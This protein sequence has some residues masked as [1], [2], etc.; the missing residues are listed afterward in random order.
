MTERQPEPVESSRFFEHGFVEIEGTD[1][2]TRQAALAVQMP[3]CLFQAIVP[4][5]LGAGFIDNFRISEPLCIWIP[6]VSKERLSLTGA[7]VDN[8]VARI[9][10]TVEHQMAVIAKTF[11][12]V[13]E[14]LTNPADM[15]PMLPL[16]T[17]VA[18]RFRCRVD[19]IPK[20]LHGVQAT[21]VDGVAEF[22]WALAC[23][24]AKVL[25]ESQAWG[26]VFELVP[27]P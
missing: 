15:V 5:L 24:L 2:K 19:D 21:P 1:A 10:T 14:L 3:C 13:A 20:V 9:N 23:V 17:Y 11:A 6:K 18:L 8:A 22:Q 12:M 4:S 16:G 27:A 7:Q 26:P 25:M